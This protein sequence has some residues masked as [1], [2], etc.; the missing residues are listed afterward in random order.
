MNAKNEYVYVLACWQHDTESVEYYIGYTTDVHRRMLEHMYSLKGYT[1]R[2][3]H[4]KLM[5]VLKVSERA[6]MFEKFLKQHRGLAKY[7]ALYGLCFHKHIGRAAAQ[8]RKIIYQFAEAH[9]SIIEECVELV[10][11]MNK[12]VFRVE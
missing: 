8:N 9:E 10:V 6:I 3:Q 7:L 4:K 12:E 11:K 1:G 2:F 5:A